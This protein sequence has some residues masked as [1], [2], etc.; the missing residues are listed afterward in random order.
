[1][2]TGYGVNPCL[3]LMLLIIFNLHGNLRHLIYLLG[4][5]INS[6]VQAILLKVDRVFKILASEVVTVAG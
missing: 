2:Q 4:G 6:V 3:V 1:M 5:A